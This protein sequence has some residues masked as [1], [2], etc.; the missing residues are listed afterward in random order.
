MQYKDY[1]KV[2]GLERSA[3]QDEIKRAFRK[4]GRKF[5]SDVSKDRQLRRD[6]RK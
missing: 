1:Y 5:H 2:L 6:S 3:T 4:L